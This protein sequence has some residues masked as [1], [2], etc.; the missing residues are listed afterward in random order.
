VAARGSVGRTRRLLVA[1]LVATASL[2]AAGGALACGSSGY[3]YAGLASAQKTYGVGAQVTAIGA[4][5]VSGANGHVAGWVGVGGPKQGPNGS[6]EWIQVGFSG[7]AGSANSQLY[8][9]VTRAGS[10]PTYH[11]VETDLPPGTTR[12]LAVL[13]L[14]GRPDWWRVWVDGRAV[15]K[16]I[17]L[18][19]SDGSWP[20]IATAESWSESK[21]GACNAFGYRFDDVVV[22]QHSGGSWRTLSDALP[23]RSGANKLV[24]PASSGSSSFEALA[25]DVLQVSRPLP[26]PHEPAPGTVLVA[27][28]RST[29]SAAAH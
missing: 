18:P 27:G 15:S 1:L 3:T 13:E 29:A 6:D 11:T 19:G 21:A 17:Y 8:F 9:E 7:F 5:A 14:A 24:M 10:S 2:V 28:T 25:G 26:K 12:Q 16:P 20:G 22:A 23:I 4:P